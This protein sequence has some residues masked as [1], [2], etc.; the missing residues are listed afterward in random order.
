MKYTVVP[1]LNDE[2]FGEKAADVFLRALGSFEKTPSVVL[3]TGNT[4]LPFFAVLRE[5]AQ[6]QALRPFNS[7]QL[8]EYL[9]LPDGD[10]RLFSRWLAHEVLDPLKISSRMIF[11]SAAD[12]SEEVNRIKAWHALNGAMDLAVIGIGENGH[13]GFNEPGAKFD[14]RANIVTLSGQTIEANT[15]YGRGDVPR[16][17]IT[18]GIGDLRRAYETI[19]LVRGER[20]AE[21]LAKAMLGEV[22]TDI[23]AS[24][25][26]QQPRLTIVADTAALSKM[27]RDIIFK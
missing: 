21:I 13:V 1:A 2:E 23:P 7:L 5:R 12:P 26:Q 14:H 11:N 17:A 25:L 8:D 15:S 19:L 22:T 24:Y 18:L 27:P 9:G 20:K 3:P 10:A 4:P 6:S 16:K